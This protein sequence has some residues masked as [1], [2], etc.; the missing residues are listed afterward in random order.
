[1]IASV[2]AVAALCA[3]ADLSAVLSLFAACGLIGWR[4]VLRAGLLS[5]SMLG[6]SLL[7]LALAIGAASA[8][9]RSVLQSATWPRRKLESKLAL[10]SHPCLGRRDLCGREP[11]CT[12]RGSTRSRRVTVL[13]VCGPFD[14]WMSHGTPSRGREAAGAAQR[15]CFVSVIQSRKHCYPKGCAAPSKVQG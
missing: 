2:E 12:R 10:P 5:A 4:A 11:L 7:A 14:G 3:S 9:G 8:G 13:N 6:A 15:T 1:M